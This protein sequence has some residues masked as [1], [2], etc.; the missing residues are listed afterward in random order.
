MIA[1]AVLGSLMLVPPQQ[2]T[3]PVAAPPPATAATL[4][5]TF[6]ALPAEK[7]RAVVAALQRRLQ[8]DRDPI[9]QRYSDRLRGLQA[10]PP[11]QPRPVHSQQTWAPTA[12]AR[13]PV[14]VD[15]P[16]YRT[17]R[18][19]FPPPPNLADLQCAVVYDW[20]QGKAAR[21]PDDLSDA[22]TFANLA[23]GYP[24]GADQTVAQIIE[25]LDQDHEQRKLA[26]WFEH[27]YAD[28]G[29]AVFA[30]ISLYDAWYSGKVVEVPDVDAIPFAVQVLGSRA[31]TSP[32][33]AGKARDR[34]YQAIADA[35]LEHRKY[36][37]LRQCAAAAF[38][39]AEPPIDPVYQGLIPR[40]HYLWALHDWDPAAL[41][42]ILGSRERGELLEA[43]DEPLAKDPKAGDLQRQAQRE[44]T[45]LAAFLREL[46]AFELAR[47]K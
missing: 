22:A 19:N 42:K 10:Y 17:T 6:T 13:L 12:P 47:N 1:A 14:P 18:A 43:V 31:F 45:D 3:A 8:L 21:L 28:R 34:L 37:T 5:A 9:L 41:A 40:F 38:V 23:H 20:S 44:L 15:A 4:I 33:P 25:L 39:A 30:G 36:R 7:Q 26:V 2:P 11:L 32:I 27:C 16:L 29:G 35:A 46:C 24:L